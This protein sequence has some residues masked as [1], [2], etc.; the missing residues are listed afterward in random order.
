MYVLEVIP[1]AT[2]PRNQSQILSYFHN[3]ALPKGAVVEVDLRNRKVKAVV[4]ESKPLKSLKLSL[5]KESSFELKN[6]SKVIS[7][8]P[9]VA[10]HQFELAMWL[11]SY[12]FAPLGQCLQTVL[13][14]FWGIKKYPIEIKNIHPKAIYDI[15]YI[16]TKNLQKHSEDYLETIQENID[17]QMLLLVPEYAHAKYF[18]EQYA[19]Y[20]PV[21][22]H[23]GLSNKE[24]FD[25]CHKIQLGEPA[26][27]IGTR[28]SLFL[29]FADLKLIIVDDEPNELYLSEMSPRYNAPDAAKKIASM[30]DAKLVINA[31]VPKMETYIHSKSFWFKRNP[32]INANVVNMRDEISAGNFSSLSR[33]L[34]DAMLTNAGKKENMALFVP[35]RGYSPAVLC[36]KC[37]EAIKCP[38][39]QVSMVSHRLP[40]LSANSY[41]LTASLIC[42]HCGHEEAMP[43]KC[44]SCGS[45]QIKSIGIGIE[46]IISAIEGFFHKRGITPVPLFRLDSDTITSPDETEETVKK[47]LDTKGSILLGTH[48]L[49]SYKYFNLGK[50]NGL[51]KLPFLGIIGMDSLSVLND[52]RTEERSA[53]TLKTLSSMCH[54]MLIQTN[55]PDDNSLRAFMGN[56][57]REFFDEE[58]SLR[59]ELFYPPFARLAILEY[60]HKNP[61]KARQEARRVYELLKRGASHYKLEDASISEPFSALIEKE[62][63]FYI[64]QIM[65]KIKK[66]TDLP[67]LIFEKDWAE[68]KKRNELFRVLPSGWRVFVD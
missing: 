21:Y 30:H 53:R 25:I 13:P 7:K 54:R 3:E 27:V 48:M 45:R 1:L 20:N 40:P 47:F 26:L 42:H 65:V 36:E 38:N 31:L 9:Q 60:R 5:K 8:I 16:A 22:M 57:L 19:K 29:P 41:K 2:L 63:G 49:L 4:L 11:S 68:I 12:Y 34:Q 24:T 17:G 6:V 43:E 14:S 66:P 62:K 18:L 64:W 33:D 50:F 15:S 39:C 23:S 58:L 28:A 61:I 32:P 67:A 52:F 37:G 46:K 35:R 10:E 51:P 55:N 59:K 56:S 44:P